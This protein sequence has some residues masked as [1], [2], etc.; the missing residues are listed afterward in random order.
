MPQLQLSRPLQ[1]EAAWSSLWPELTQLD[2]QLPP[3][4]RLVH[5]S[6][7]VQPGD[8]FFALSG[9]RHQ[10]EEFLAE[11]QSLGARLLVVEGDLQVEQLT[12]QCIRLQLPHLKARL[13]QLLALSTQVDFQ[14]I[15]SL[16]VTGTNGKSSVAHFLCQLYGL[17]GQ[18][19]ALVGTL[20]YGSLNALQPASHTTPDLFT[21]HQ[22]YLDWS[23]QGVSRVVLEAS[24]HALD[25]GRLDG[26]SLGTGVFTNLTRDHLDY[27]VT[28]E[29][30]AEAKAK[31]FQRPELK[32]AVLNLDDAYG[33]LWLNSLPKPKKLSYSLS[34]AQADLYISQ[35]VFNDQGMSGLL[36]WQHQTWPFSVPLL[37]AFNLANLLAALAVLLAEGYSMA[38]LLALLPQLQAVKG[39]MQRLPSQPDQPSV[40]VDFAHTPDA[41]EQLLLGVAAHSQG[42]VW[43]VLGCGG[44][45]DKGKRPFMAQIAG[46]LADQV[47]VTDDNPRDE[48]PASIRQQLLQELPEALEVADRKQAITTAITHAAAEDWIVIAGKGHETYQEIAG[49]RLPCDDVAL[50][51]AALEARGRA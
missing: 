28:L 35:P 3:C 33:R 49:R 8:A 21:L 5:D 24:S 10:G 47:V 25:Q 14:S 2:C 20:G 37:G 4:Q 15:S 1:P 22:L 31:L 50:A 7:L 12:S 16:A 51:C 11:A 34:S 40:V 17:L 43:C 29:A 19:A 27:H 23:R 45:R 6:R 30:Y 18:T 38:E 41:L 42:K 9:L 32:I 44:N 46:R 39:R 13:G 36:H 48:N 26:V